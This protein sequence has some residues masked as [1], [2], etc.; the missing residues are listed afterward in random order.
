MQ[1]VITIVFQRLQEV[2]GTMALELIQHMNAVKK[3]IYIYQVNIGGRYLLQKVHVIVFL[4]LIVQVQLVWMILA[5]LL[6]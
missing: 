2:D 3:I 1:V 6:V 5:I 4:E